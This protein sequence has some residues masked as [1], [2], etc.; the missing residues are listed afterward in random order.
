MSCSTKFEL[1]P[2]SSVSANGQMKMETARQIRGQET[3]AIQH[4]MI[5]T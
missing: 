2:I 1:N 3:A 5:K 4:S